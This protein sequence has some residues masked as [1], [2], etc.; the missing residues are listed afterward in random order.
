M[1]IV[2]VIARAALTSPAG[3]YL[4]ASAANAITTPQALATVRSTHIPHW[5]SYLGKALWAN[6]LQRHGDKISNDAHIYDLHTWWSNFPSRT[7]FRWK[8]G[9][10]SHGVR[11]WVKL[12]YESWKVTRETRRP[13][14]YDRASVEARRLGEPR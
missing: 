8:Y 13:G 7:A 10:R 11:R 2:V 6:G 5:A 3:Q 9:I 1:K 14:F 4:L 12:S